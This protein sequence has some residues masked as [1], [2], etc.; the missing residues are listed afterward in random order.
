MCAGI[1]VNLNV[2]SVMAGNL[3]PPAPCLHAL[4]MFD[5]LSA[6]YAANQLISCHVGG[7]NNLRKIS[8]HTL[9]PHKNKVCAML[10][11][12]ELLYCINLSHVVLLCN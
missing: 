1:V 3:S 6:C 4:I 2:L 8:F 11:H 7:K 9:V 12:K 5:T 10:H